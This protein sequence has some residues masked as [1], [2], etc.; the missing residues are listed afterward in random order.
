MEGVISVN[1]N[2]MYKLHTTRS[3]DFMNLTLNTIRVPKESDVI[4]GV[5]DTGNIMAD[6]SFLLPFFLI[7]YILS[8]IVVGSYF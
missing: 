1:P 2:R 7:M 4:I 5:L 6:G 3:W 8:N